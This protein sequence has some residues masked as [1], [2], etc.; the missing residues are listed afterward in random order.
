MNSKI[1]LISFLLAFLSSCGFKIVKQDFLNNYKINKIDINGEKQTSFLLRNKFKNQ[2]N[3]APKSID[4]LIN[5]K[6]SKSIKEKNIRN[7]ITKYEIKIL[8][9]VE[10][11]LVEENFYDKINIEKKGN[12]NVSKQ[13]SN[14]ITNE[15]R[16]TH[17]LVDD[18]SN[19]IL[20]ELKIRFN[21][22]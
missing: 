13:Y 21:D 1:I 19:Q 22:L 14:T 10:Y 20:K 12:Y 17:D 9:D 18:I 6:K 11:K 8:V 15:K 4:L 5:L 7:E 16:L 2:N 3:N